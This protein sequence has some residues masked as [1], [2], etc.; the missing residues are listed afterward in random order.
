MA[1]LK[2]RPTRAGVTRFVA[3]LEDPRRRKE[4]RELLRL[5]R[6]VTGKRPVLW[7]TSIIGYGQYHYRYRSGRE[8]DWMVTGF[9]P[10]KQALSIYIMPGFGR[11][12]A[13]MKRLGKYRTGVSCLYVRKLEDVDVDVLRELVAASVAD[14]ATLYPCR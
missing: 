13:L 12:T 14:M 5:F 7:G 8:G 9:S 1:E 6:E 10:R 3:A 2:T 11:Y 4:S